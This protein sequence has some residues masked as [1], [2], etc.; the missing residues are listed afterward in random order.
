MPP[1]ATEPK[2]VAAGSLYRRRHIG[3]PEVFG[4]GTFDE[5]VGRQRKMAKVLVTGAAGFVGFHL[6]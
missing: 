5:G 4:C 2:G 6:C 1:P 3:R